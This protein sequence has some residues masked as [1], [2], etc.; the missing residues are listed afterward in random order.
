MLN[1]TSKEREKFLI[2]GLI[3]KSIDKQK[4]LDSLNELRE[5]VKTYGG[6]V[7]DMIIQVKKSPDPA[8]HIGKGKIEEI[9]KWDGFDT[10]LFDEPLSPAQIRNIEKITGKKTIDRRDIILDIFAKHA[11]TSVSK[12][13]VELAK[14]RFEIPRLIGK[15]NEFSRTGGGI[16]TRGP[17][18]QKLEIDRR[19]IRERIKYL[20]DK[21]KKIEK[22]LEI[23]RKRRKDIFTIALL[24]YTNAGK[25]TLMNRLT[26]ANTYVDNKLFATLDPLTRIGYTSNGKKFLLTDTV[27]F[28][29]NIPHQLIASFKST[30]ME[31]TFV[32]LRLI[33]ID[34]SNER[35]SVQI[36]ESLNILKLLGIE[37]KDFIFVFNKID[38]VVDFMTVSYLKNKYE[39]SVFISALRGDGISELDKMIEERIRKMEVQNYNKISVR[40]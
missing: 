27:G 15:G 8:Y 26:N 5:L 17:G 16:G 40:N 31:A 25:S 4:K 22:T 38:L 36:E 2:V 3:N 19:K 21:L 12:I 37:D 10:I 9:S 23:Q 29:Q 13:E 24:G 11:K 35:Y 33:V 32:D 28:I 6:E 34:V 39:N 18:E 7:I 14:L 30:L 20:E 1:S